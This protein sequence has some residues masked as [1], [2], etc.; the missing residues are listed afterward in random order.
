MM[1]AAARV[2]ILCVIIGW[3]SLT[4]TSVTAQSYEE[5]F[6][7]YTV[8]E[9][10]VIATDDNRYSIIKAFYSPET[11]MS[12]VYVTIMYVDYKSSVMNRD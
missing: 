8:L 9:R 3:L 7:N 10:A 6:T 5:C 1:P 4:T 12:A 11:T 2:L